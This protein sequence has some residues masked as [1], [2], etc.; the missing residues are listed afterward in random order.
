MTLVEMLVVVVLMAT[1]LSISS[2]GLLRRGH[3]THSR[4]AA[5][6]DSAQAAAIRSGRAI[7]LTDSSGR[8]VRFLPDGGAIGLGIDRLTGRQR[9]ESF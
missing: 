5:R 4:W 3:E 6:V 9:N 7:V 2:L 1:L 8:T